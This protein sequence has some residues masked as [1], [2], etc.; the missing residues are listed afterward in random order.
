MV[1][2]IASDRHCESS[3]GLQINIL[4]NAPTVNGSIEPQSVYARN[5]IDK[6]LDLQSVFVDRDQDNLTDFALFIY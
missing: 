3:I 1:Y 6:F 2:L 4:N 5:S